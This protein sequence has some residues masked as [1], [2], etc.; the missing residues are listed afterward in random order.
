MRIAVDGPTSD[1]RISIKGIM[2]T[3]TALRH[4]WRADDVKLEI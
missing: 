2:R 3:N 4:L 1:V